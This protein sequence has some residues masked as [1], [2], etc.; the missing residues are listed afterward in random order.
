MQ[1]SNVPQGGE[2]KQTEGTGSQEPGKSAD[3]TSAPE[4]ANT[5]QNT[6]EGSGDGTAIY[7]NNMMQ[8]MGGMPGQLGYGFNGSQGNFNNGMAWNGMNPMGGMP[9]MMGGG[10]FNMNPMGMCL[11]SH[12]TVVFTS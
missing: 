1:P 9:N 10:N 4:D 6:T 12:T 3:P 7:G 8:N 11:R 5:V 2:P